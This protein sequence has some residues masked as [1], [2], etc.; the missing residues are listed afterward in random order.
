M[1][2]GGTRF[3]QEI[4]ILEQH[5][6]RNKK[7]INDI[8]SSKDMLNKPFK[9]GIIPI[10]GFWHI[11]LNDMLWIGGG[12]Y[13]NEISKLNIRKN[14]LIKQEKRE[15]GLTKK[16]N[17]DLIDKKN[18]LDKEIDE[19]KLKKAMQPKKQELEE[20]IK[21][22]LWEDAKANGLL[23]KSFTSVDKKTLTHL[24]IYESITTSGPFKLNRTLKS[25]HYE[26]YKKDLNFLEDAK[27]QQYVSYFQ[28]KGQEINKLQLEI[29][30]ND[31][32]I[33]IL[34][35][36]VGKKAGHPKT[37]T[38]LNGPVSLQQRYIPPGN[39]YPGARFTR[40]LK[41]IDGNVYETSVNEID[42]GYNYDFALSSW[43]FIHAQAPNFYIGS[44]KSKNIIQW[45]ENS[46]Q[47][48]YNINDN[49]LEIKTKNNKKVIK[50]PNILLQKWINLVINYDGGHFDI[51][52][53]GKLIKTLPQTVYI[54][55]DTLSLKISQKNGV[56][57]GICNVVH[58]ASH[59]TKSQIINNYETYKDKDPPIL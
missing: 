42:G 16:I 45:S 3:K 6:K 56:R 10:G 31:E 21:D 34:K 39:K 27:I 19:L 52:L 40:K 13:D 17:Q 1:K 38:L 20:K 30:K 51:F 7:E 22:I 33:K 4:K 14:K 5:N 23:N 9:S 46:F 15:Q 24:E 36:K 18:K 12:Y 55:P 2:D 54:M 26:K 32:N 41:T 50:I 37:V 53:D 47:I 59:L 48:L 58:F 35:G 25:E 11:L 49:S 28:S 29:Q 57:G 43:I 8:R 44:E